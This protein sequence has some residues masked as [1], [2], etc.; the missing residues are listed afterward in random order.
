MD[1][2]KTDNPTGQTIAVEVTS[3]T[4][5]LDCAIREKNWDDARHAMEHLQEALEQL[6]RM[7]V[8]APVQDPN[9]ALIDMS[10][11]FLEQ[12]TVTS[13]AASVR[14]DKAVEEMRDRWIDGRH[15]NTEATRAAVKTEMAGIISVALARGDL[16]RETP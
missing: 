3:A 4:S 8:A 11:M 2:F 14:I 1:P 6:S 13:D 16:V 15:H 9:R 12:L 10:D 7:P 5:A